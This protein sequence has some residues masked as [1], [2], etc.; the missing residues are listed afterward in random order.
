VGAELAREDVLKGAKEP[1]V[2]HDGGDAITPQTLLQFARSF[3]G[4]P[5]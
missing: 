4:K 2:S 5:D 1:L 3:R